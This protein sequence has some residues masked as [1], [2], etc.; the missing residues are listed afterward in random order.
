MGWASGF[1]SGSRVVGDILDTYD[2]SKQRNELEQIAKATP[3]SYQGFTPEQGE[4]LR[5]AAESGADVQFDD[6]TKAYVVTPGAMGAD[7]AGPVAPVQRIAQQGVTDFLGS[8]TAA[9]NDTQIANARQRAMAGV[10]MKSD[11]VTGQRMMRDVTQGERDDKR[12]GWEEDRMRRETAK[13]ADA[14]KYIDGLK[15]LHKSSEFSKNQAADAQAAEKYRTDLA[16]HQ[17]RVQAGDHT[18]VAPTAPSPSTYTV[19]QSLADGLTLAQY[20]MANGKGDPDKL[21]SLAKARQAMEQ[22]GYTKALKLAQ[23]GATIDQIAAEFNRSGSDRFDPK[24]VVSDKIVDKGQGIKTRVITFKDA[25]GKVQSIDAMAELDALGAADKLIANMFEG[26]RIDLA[27]N[28]DRRDAQR[29]SASVAHTVAQTGILNQTL[30]EKKELAEL[31][32]TYGEA[33][34]SGDAKAIDSASKK[35]H[36]YSRTGKAG[37][38]ASA[39]AQKVDLIM[40]ANPGMALSKAT[41]IALQK[42]QTSP[43]DDYMRLMTPSSTGTPRP[44]DVEPAMARMHGANWMH[45]LGG[46]APGSMGADPKAIAIRD[47]KSL[48]MEE[49]RSRLK[50]LGYQ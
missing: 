4:A 38:A 45:K 6:A 29:T 25:Q 5:K 50:A 16:A 32:K 44:E 27:Q 21:I 14:Q 13:E 34:D 42:A 46:V 1:E 24:A 12:F 23:G 26:K 20:N 40:Q 36:A 47:D 7:E 37:E 8:R 10:V 35:L 18:G 43:K 30:E 19:G 41:D 31:K 39:F 28:A 17:A 15:D 49:K 11:P 48:S 33:L 9:M 3:E 22:E 2:K